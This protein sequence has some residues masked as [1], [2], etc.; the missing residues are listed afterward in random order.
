MNFLK[1]VIA[2]LQLFT[3]T[4]TFVSNVK[5]TVCLWVCFL[6]SSKSHSQRGLIQS[7]IHPCRK[8]DHCFPEW[9]ILFRNWTDPCASKQSN[10]NYLKESVSKQV[11]TEKKTHKIWYFVL[12]FFFKPPCQG[13]CVQAIVVRVT[14]HLSQMHTGKKPHSS[15][16]ITL[17]LAGLCNGKAS[18]SVRQ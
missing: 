1:S 13:P 4:S 8:A 18:V 16:L 3:T 6:Y 5:E 10:Y 11:N 9:W 7:S 2:P 15:L 14:L 12:F 17:S